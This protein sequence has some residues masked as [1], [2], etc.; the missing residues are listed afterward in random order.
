M[1][2]TVSAHAAEKSARKLRGSE[3]LL[4]V[5][6]WVAALF[7]NG[8]RT[9]GPVPLEATLLPVFWVTFAAA[10]LRGPLV[11]FL[12]GLSIPVLQA[13]IQSHF[14]FE[15]T[16]VLGTELAVFILAARILLNRAPFLWWTAALSCVAAHAAGALLLA[17]APG[18]IEGLTD[19]KSYFLTTLQFAVPG[20][21]LLTLL[22]LLLVKIRPL[23]E[24]WDAL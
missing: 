11:A 18:R 8:V 16:A 21:L 22:N 5:A 23:P 20:I 3:A 12:V 9:S 13:G 6:L 10:Y 1:N 24:D 7:V 15:A 14:D 2:P 19:P 4:L 17:W